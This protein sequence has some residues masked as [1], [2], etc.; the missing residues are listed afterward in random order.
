MNMI[1]IISVLIV[2]YVCVQLCIIYIGNPWATCGRRVYAE[3]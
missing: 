3:S 1:I 2:A